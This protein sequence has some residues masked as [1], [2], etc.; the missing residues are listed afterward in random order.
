[1]KLLLLFAFLLVLLLACNP[2]KDRT[3]PTQNTSEV[4]GL[5]HD[6]MPHDLLHIIKGR[7]GC[8]PKS[9]FML[10]NNQFQT[11]DIPGLNMKGILLEKAAMHEGN[12]RQ[13]TY[14]PVIFVTTQ[15]VV[16]EWNGLLSSD[17]CT[18][19]HS[20][21]AIGICDSSLGSITID[22]TPYYY[23]VIGGL[24]CEKNQLHPDPNT[25]PS[26]DCRPRM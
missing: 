3:T 24:L 16:N 22:K 19:P 1:M 14:E 21:F 18:P 12:G 15:A 6:T 17:A 26:T 2:N 10:K 20:E 5:S 23:F 7:N 9:W 25:S 13:A 11:V 4:S 8:V